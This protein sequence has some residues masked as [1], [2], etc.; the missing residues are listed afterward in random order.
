MLFEHARFPTGK[1]RERSHGISTTAI[2]HPFSVVVV[3]VQC[4]VLEARVLACTSI[5]RQSST[6]G[7]RCSL[8]I[9]LES[10][11]MLGCA[12]LQGCSGNSIPFCPAPVSQLSQS[13]IGGSGFGRRSLIRRIVGRPH[14]VGERW[15]VSSCADCDRSDSVASE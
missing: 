15:S 13:K 2:G 4:I 12:K 11:I 3:A 7:Y 8:T 5:A 14:M 1:T 10:R 6:F 9:I